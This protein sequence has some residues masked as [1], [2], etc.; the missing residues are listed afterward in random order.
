MDA[1]LIVVIMGQ[2]C[3]K[4][5]GMCL[6]SVKDADQIVYCDG[7]SDNR[8]W[9]NPE[10]EDKWFDTNVWNMKV[11]EN[12]FDK[13]D[14]AMNG[15]QRNFYLNYIKE[16]YPNDWCIVLD[17]DEVVED[18]QR[19]KNIMGY[20]KDIVG[21]N[22]KMRHFI[23]D[24]G[25]ED[26][27]H[28][29][30]FVPMRLFKISAAKSYPEHSHPVLQVEGGIA[31]TTVTT[32]WHLGHL[33]IEYMNYINNRYKQHAEDSLIHT[34]EFLRWWRDSHLFGRY[35]V[36]VVNP[37][38]IPKIIYDGL[39][40]NFEEMYS[41]TEQIEMKH[42]LMVKQWY[43][44][45]KPESVLDLGCGRGSYLHYWQWFAGKTMGLDNNQWAVNN[46][47]ASN[48]HCADISK[49]DLKTEFIAGKPCKAD[50]WDLITA[51]DVLEHLNDAE[52]KNVLQ[53]MAEGGKKFLFSIPFIGDPNLD[54]DKTHKQFMTKM[55]WINYIQSFGIKIKEPPI[56]WLFKEQILI[57]EL[58][59]ENPSCEECDMDL[60]GEIYEE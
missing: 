28:E 11:I 35:P 41:N 22:V 15:K 46:A 16:N 38:E 8:F 53:M 49:F 42:H 1:K 47:F 51:I 59:Q 40:L 5:I 21:M 48:I 29:T 56:H 37:R 26:A 25:H 13:S 27:T 43:D 7:G 14:K 23:G 39:N 36:R 12:K 34:P 55:D 9:E 57:G 52:L 20:T 6:E 24:L 30:H 10:W 18:Y 45:F 33:P 4:H 44:Y 60:D 50:R 54:A 17:A 32:I 58:K 3:E 19:L 31:N 2:N